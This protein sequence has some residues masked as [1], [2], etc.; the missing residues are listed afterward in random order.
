M[1]TFR[2]CDQRCFTVLIPVYKSLQESS[3]HS[4]N[5]TSS[6]SPQSPCKLSAYYKIKVEMM[7]I[8][9]NIRK[10]PKYGLQHLLL[11]MKEHKCLPALMKEILDYRGCSSK[12]IYIWNRF[13]L[14][15]PTSLSYSSYHCTHRTSTNTW[16]CTSEKFTFLQLATM[17]TIQFMLQNSYY[18]SN[19]PWI[20]Y[21]QEQDTCFSPPTQHKRGPHI[22][23]PSLSSHVATWPTGDKLLFYTQ[24][25]Y[26]WEYVPRHLT[27]AF[28]IT[29]Y[30]TSV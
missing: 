7:C 27:H 20:I 8:I 26:P 4:K 19:T 3:I 1:Y 13:Y 25:E 30:K 28:T 24:Q 2:K 21:H 29:M 16:N 23:L 5:A 14:Y 15:H 12:N 10:F 18:S 17:Y 22:D 11:R 6:L 9:E